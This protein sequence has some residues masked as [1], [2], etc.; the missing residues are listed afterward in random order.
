MNSMQSF[1]TVEASHVSSHILGGLQKVIAWAALVGAAQDSR[2][3]AASMAAATLMAVPEIIPALMFIGRSAPLHM[4]PAPDDIHNRIR[5]LE[6][7]RQSPRIRL[8]MSTSEIKF[9]IWQVTLQ[10]HEP[11]I[12]AWSLS[13][14]AQEWVMMTHHHHHAHPSLALNSRRVLLFPS[15]LA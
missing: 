7:A 9:Y 8:T 15:S 4:L 11:R 3:A 14:L 1:T 6:R 5:P 10:P 2:S 13:A 12:V